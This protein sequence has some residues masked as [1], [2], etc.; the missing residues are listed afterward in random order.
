LFLSYL[1]Q[2]RGAAVID[3]KEN[4]PLEMTLPYL[5][6]KPMYRLFNY[7]DIVLTGAT[8]FEDL[9]VAGDLYL[10]SL[11]DLACIGSA[12]TT[13][14]YEIYAWMDN[15]ELGSLTG[16]QIEILTEG[17]DERV[18]GPIESFASRSANVLGHFTNIPL[19]GTY[20]KA[21]NIMLRGIQAASAIMGWSKPIPDVKPTFVKNLPYQ[22]GALCV[23]YDTAFKI[24]V[25]PHQELT[26]DPSI[27][28]SSED[29]MMISFLCNR[30]SYLTNF[31]WAP[32]DAL[33]TPIFTS[34]VTPYQYSRSTYLLKTYMQPTALCFAALPFYWWRG[35]L[36]YRIDVVCSGFHRGKLAII[37]EPNLGQ[38]TTIATTLTTNKQYIA[39]IDIQETQS[40][41]F[42]IK[43]ASHRAWLVQQNSS[44]TI[45]YGTLSAMT[46]IN[47][48]TSCNGFFTI[49]PYT[50]LV[51]PDGDSV[52]VNVFVKS[53]NM[54]FNYPVVSYLPTER[55][56]QSGSYAVNSQ[57]V[58]CIDLNKS[59]ASDEKIAEEY[60]GEL[61]ISYRTLLKRFIWDRSIGAT[62]AASVGGNYVTT[63]FV[64][65]RQPLPQ[66]KT[67]AAVGGSNNFFDHLRYAYMGLKGSIRF[68]YHVE[69]VLTNDLFSTA[70]VEHLTPVD[71]TIPDSAGTSTTGIRMPFQG[72][73]R[74]NLP[75][76]TGIEYEIPFYSSNLFAYSFSD[77]LDGAYAATPWTT[78]IMEVNWVR[79]HYVA[80][81][82][83]NDN[84]KVLRVVLES[85][86][87]EDFSFLRFTGAPWFTYTT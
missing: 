49:V 57:P 47:L 81:S 3:Y 7:N 35:D 69:G 34:C 2:A 56:I 19:I 11:T 24:A 6:H 54:H 86:A 72:G 50:R 62:T 74:F 70:I 64:N 10:F 87:G 28:G 17:S 22:N 46:P 55:V 48:V 43:W 36:E 51:S 67:G 71:S 30:E 53:P 60:F 78:D 65:F 32:T 9:N 44:A 12:D 45:N 75:S 13:I 76:N 33:M 37:Y 8:P 59:T 83:F 61:P 15:V 18:V 84:A 4:Q 21:S 1:S 58:S 25:D 23:G 40:I 29:E 39:L 52:K 16:T 14:A 73:V 41:S 63:S 82:S 68:R 80:L 79:V 77:T 42:C 31:T 38:A 85:A 26:V 66:Y 5:F 20:A 27:A